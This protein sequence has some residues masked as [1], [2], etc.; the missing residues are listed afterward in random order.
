M[1]TITN[2]EKLDILERALSVYKLYRTRNVL[3]GL[4]HCML[5]AIEEIYGYDFFHIRPL[6]T[7]RELIPEFNREFLHGTTS[8]YNSYWWPT[9]DDYA[10]IKALEYL[11]SIYK[12]KVLKEQSK[13]SIK[14]TLKYYL[15]FLTNL[16][17]KNK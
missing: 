5:K 4:C 17:K 14:K 7:M 15:S 8:H 10:R 16:F 6:I 1:N 13:D 3:T 11:I 2:K 9:E 12:Q